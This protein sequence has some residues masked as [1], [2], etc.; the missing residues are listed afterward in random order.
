MDRLISILWCLDLSSATINYTGVCGSVPVE[1]SE[2]GKGGKSV[3]T[4]AA[5]WHGW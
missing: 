3:P 5:Q 1:S 4:G 2:G